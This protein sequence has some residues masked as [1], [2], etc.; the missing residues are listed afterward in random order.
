MKIL[1]TGANGFIGRALCSSLIKK[2]EAVK[3][4]LRSA[5]LQIEGAEVVLIT[6]FD[7]NTNWIDALHGV[8]VIVHLAARVHVMNDSESN[9]IN[10]FRA[11]NVDSTLNIA[12]QAASVGVRRFIYISS[13]KVN[14]ELTLDGRPFTEIDPPSPKDD[15]GQ[16]K[17]EAEQGLLQMATK[18]GMEIVIVRPPLVYGPGVKA[19]FASLM[20]AVQKGWPLPFG[21]ITNRRS[22]VSLDN[23][24]DFIN[25]CIDHPC[26]ANQIFLVSDGVDLSTAELASRMAHIAGVSANLLCIPVW[27]LKMSFFLLNRRDIEHRLCGNLQVDISKSKNIL[28]WIPPISIEEGLR[29][30][31][32]AEHI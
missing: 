15:Y 14:G 30:A 32:L 20:R 13:I 10:A 19:N 8:E 5:N 9:P 24:V 11:V 3:S 1:V 12:L 23:L 2:G 18:T 25:I 31:M 7:A 28:G 17:Y 4:V 16:S 6:D 22:L 21:G 26:A 27:V 29:R